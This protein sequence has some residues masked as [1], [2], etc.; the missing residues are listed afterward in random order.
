[1][2]LAFLLWLSSVLPQPIADPLC[3]TTTIYLESRNQSVLGQRA[4]AEVA[5]RRLNDGNWGHNVCEVVTA[6]KQFAP[7][8]IKPDFE[9][10]NPKAWNR[11]AAIAWEV[12]LDARKP[13]ERR[14]E[15]VPGADH[16]L[17]SNL[18]NPPMWAQG[19]PLARIGDHSFYKVKRL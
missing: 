6:P 15:V 3:L 19:E 11:A 2:K 18:E 5:M 12:F 13:Q 17:V 7:T 8:L 14:R 16:F 4:V 9:L 1:M 10:D